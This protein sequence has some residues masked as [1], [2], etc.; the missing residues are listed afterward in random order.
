MATAIAS[1]TVNPRMSHFLRR[2]SW[3]YLWMSNSISAAPSWVVSF[4]S[5]IGDWPR[6]EGAQPADDHEQGLQ[7]NLEIQERGSLPHIFDVQPDP[8][9]ERGLAPATHLP[10]A[11]NSWPDLETD[12]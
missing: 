4:I 7:E 1:S 9:V 10:E 5:V 11:R 8:V 2:T 3:R 12:I 6:S